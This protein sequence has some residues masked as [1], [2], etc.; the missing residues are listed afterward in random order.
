MPATTGAEIGVVTQRASTVARR[1]AWAALALACLL[2]LLAA[3]ATWG[4][5]R[6]LRSQ[7]PVVLGE[8]LGRPVSVGEVAINPFTL[9]FALADLAIG[10]QGAAEPALRVASVAAQGSWR[11]LI[12]GAPVI[13]DL[14]IDGLRARLARDAEGRLS[15]DDVLARLRARPP[16]PA[17]PPPRFVLEAAELAN[18]ELV[19]DDRQIGRTHRLAGI[20]LTLPRLSSL[21]DD[22][23]RPV[24]ARLALELDGVPVRLRASLL[25]F[26][27]ARSA[28]VELELSPLALPPYLGY[29]PRE[30]P[31]QLRQGSLSASLRIEATLPVEAAPTLSIA[32]DAT[33][34]GV[35]LRAP[36]GGDLLA[37]DAL[38]VR[39]IAAQPLASRVE[40][41]G[42]E[43]DAPR[44]AVLRR[45]TEP[46]FFESVLRALPQVQR[47]AAAEPAPPGAAASEGFRW[48]VGELVLRDGRVELRDERF[49]PQPLAL[50][51]EGFA[52]RLG[53]VSDAFDPTPFELAVA[54]DGGE[55]VS[56]KGSLRAQPLVVD[57]DIAV[58]AVPLRRWWWMA[59]PG[60]QADLVDGTLSLKTRLN[61]EDQGAGP[62]LRLSDL[63][64]KL[65][66]L[67]LRQ[68]WNARELLALPSVTLTG[69][70]LDLAARRVAL[71]SLEMAGG[72]LA[73]VRDREGELNLLRAL[74]PPPA[75]AATAGAASPGRAPV[76]VSPATRPRASA[77]V[78]AAAPPWRVSLA[79]FALS[80][81]S[82]SFR[83]LGSGTRGTAASSE[84][85]LREL[86]L[87]VEDL[88]DEPGRRARVALRTRVGDAGRLE[89]T[90]S[91]GLAPMAA[92]LRVDARAIGL[93]PARP[94]V[95]ERLRMDLAAGAV[96]ARGD[97]ALELPAGHAPKVAW[98]GDL[99][100]A[101]FHALTRSGDELL[102]WRVLS[103]EGIDA[104]VAPLSVTIAQIAL[105]DFYSRLIIDPQGR[106]N[107]QD[108]A[109]AEAPAAASDAGAANPAT[110]ATE[111][112]AAVVPPVARPPADGAGA[113]T[114]AP[115][116]LP[117]R[118]GRIALVNGNIDFSDRFIRPNYSANLT[119]MTGFV[120]ALGPDTAGEL[121]LRGRVD[122]AG[123]VEIAGTINPFAPS[124]QLDLKAQARD[125]DLPRATPYAVKYL[126]YGIEKGKL[127]ARLQY[128]IVGRQLEA[129]NEITLDQLTFGER[130]DSP[131]AT[132]LPV[133]FAVSLLKDRHGVIDVK[134]PI[135]GSLDDPQFSVGGLVL[136]I[137]FNLIAKAVTA[138]FTLLA[139]L[140]GG[141]DGE[142]SQIDFDAG[143]SALT[144]AA[145][146]RLGTLARALGDRPALR[147]DL[148]GRADPA[149][150]EAALRRQAFDRRLRT[151][152]LRL[153]GAPVP[154]GGLDVVPIEEAE[155]PRLLLAA[156]RAGEFPK[157]RDD[158]GRLRE[159][160]PEVM[161][162]MLLDDIRIDE[163]AL[164]ALADARA[165]AAKEWLIGRGIEGERLF[166]VAPKLGGGGAAARVDLTLR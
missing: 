119:G 44:V 77:P 71:G 68:R 59:A 69:S 8:T 121:L 53:R 19:V 87:R 86:S 9:R 50:R 165:H 93:L 78:V 100:L 12:A 15:I 49:A 117:V 58:D 74:S 89:A 2:A 111:A 20:G 57:A 40:I 84:A 80:G 75:A 115:A 52:L 136:R 133:L 105:E 67:V 3:A 85:S 54:A 60:L 161:A 94:F 152:K 90:G 142:M 6:L 144:E 39:A 10:E 45:A 137:I 166:V 107:L 131:T 97:L 30:L 72:S 81:A 48:S 141:A 113:A 128:R 98:K 106:F 18:A 145:G 37:F 157:P 25:P 155:R 148:A 146:E 95:A 99:H 102:R 126:G 63:S 16:E 34:A 5:P 153:A 73:L 96:S 62:A 110:P 82:V 35:D 116:A 154:A 135:S 147:L 130:V 118:I 156:W 26:A 43:L 114:P 7:L 41:G 31:V 123:S 70:S 28:S 138:P 76:P 103:V 149:A 151:A 88:S 162:Q 32:G 11:S 66:S 14:R 79:Q 139:N 143:R 65:G 33:L 104:A 22:R 108:L 159:Q 36:D 91:V 51:L 112:A 29:L 160:P 125:I 132:Q 122:N 13:A 1:L 56:A 83:Q 21:P 120:S 134:L 27:P 23:E 109:M 127:S 158:Q 42:I 64:A 46:R 140:F 92:R 129:D 55:R 4:L 150:D 124:L 101:D 17:G 47:S 38:R 163:A 61:L 24:E 164:V